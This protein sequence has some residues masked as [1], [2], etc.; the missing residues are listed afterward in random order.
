MPVLLY[1]VWAFV[2]PGLTPSSARRPAVGPA[3]AAL[4]RARRRRRLRRP[5]VRDRVPLQ[6]HRRRTCV[7]EPAAGQY[8]DFVTTMFLAFGLVME[9]PIVLVGLSRVGIVTS[10]RLA[11]SRRMVILGIAIFSAVAT[12]GG[13]LVSP[14]VLGGTMYLLFELTTFCSSSAAAGDRPPTDERADPAGRRPR[15]RAAPSSSSAACP[16]PA[17]PPRPSC[18]RTSATRSSTTC[19]ASCCPSWPSSSRRTASASPASRSS[20]TCGPATPRWPSAAMRGALEGRGI[21]PAGRLPR[22]ARRRP[23]PALQRDAPPPP[24]RRRAG[25]RQLDRRGASA[26]RRR[27]AAEADVVVDTSDLS[28]RELRERLFAPAGRP[29]TGP[30]SSRS[31]SS[32]SASSTACRSRPTSCSTSGSCRTRTTSPSCGQLSGLTEAVRTFV[33]DQPVAERFLEFLGEFLE[34]AIPAYVAEGKTRLTIAIG[35]TGGYHRSIVIAEELAAWLRERGLR[36]G[37]GLPPRAGPRATIDAVNLRRWLTP[38]IG[39]KRWLL[40]V[41]AGRARSW[42]LAVAH[43]LRQVTRDIE[44]G[45]PPD[46]LIDVADPPVPAVRAARRDP[47]GRRARRSFV[48]GSYRVVRALTEPLRSAPDAEQPLVEVIYQKRFLARGPRIVAIGGGTG[49]LDAAARAQG[50]HQQ[51]DGDRHRRRRRRLVGRAARRSSASRRSATSA[52]ASRPSPTPSR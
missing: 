22:G 8:F 10:E 3:R 9:F 21:R 41:F 49:P 6:L 20:S 46:S 48:F 52:T 42:R 17:R 1:Q 27:C 43:V 25:H 44:P 14:F 47:R 40:V 16:A 19:P 24:A 38:G 30:T 4:L 26:A 37:R 18:S 45:G 5:A 33:L 35:C 15:R 39:V 7:A 34:F 36:A 50:A 11:A 28:L 23:D 13:D 31:S 32:A 51:P 12:P 2:S 29:T